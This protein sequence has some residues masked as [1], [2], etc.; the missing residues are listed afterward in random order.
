[1]KIILFIS[2]FL[3]QLCLAQQVAGEVVGEVV[4]TE[5]VPVFGADVFIDDGLGH[6]YQAKTDFDGRFR[7]YQIPVGDH[8][9]NVHFVGYT[10]K[11]IPVKVRRDGLYD[12]G[13]IVIE[14][15]D[16]ICICP[17]IIEPV[18]IDLF[19]H[20]RIE[21]ASD[22]IQQSINRFNIEQL[23]FGSSSEVQSISDGNEISIRGARSGNYLQ[24][25]DGV[26]VIGDARIPSASY[27]K[28]TVYTNGIPAN[29]G[30]TTG[31]VID[32]QTSSYFDLY[33]QWEEEQLS[34]GR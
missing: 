7:I 25:I 1:M 26:K 22:E 30:D 32:I 11:G 10:L 12:C 6:L 27:H 33:R 2:L 20:T 9:L 21:L 34:N 4:D 18:R 24:L 14:Y 3:P 13:V 16:N 17:P 5:G 31:G 19:E 15:D 8:E 29:Y 28:I 23:V